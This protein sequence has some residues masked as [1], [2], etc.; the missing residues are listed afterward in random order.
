[1]MNTCVCTPNTVVSW[2]VQTRYL[3][4]S[5]K[6]NGFRKLLATCE[7]LAPFRVWQYS[8]LVGLTIQDSIYIIIIL[9]LNDVTVI[10]STI[11]AQWYMPST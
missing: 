4:K 1:M 10:Y 2:R 11:T 5:S 7:R 3:D 9:E 8:I 6:T